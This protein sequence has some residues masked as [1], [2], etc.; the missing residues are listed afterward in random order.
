MPYTDRLDYLA[1]MNMNLGWALCVEK[2]LGLQV[3]EKTRHLR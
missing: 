1:A 3:S 2:L